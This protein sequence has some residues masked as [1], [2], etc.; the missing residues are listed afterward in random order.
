MD[1][2]DSLS[3]DE[4][5]Q[6]SHVAND[7]CVRLRALDVLPLCVGIVVTVEEDRSLNAA[8]IRSR[9]PEGWDGG[10]VVAR[11]RAVGIEVLDTLSMT[12]L[13]SLDPRQH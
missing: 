5:P 8:G 6:T 3:Q 7:A 1:G 10:D 9:M 12:A 13:A 2:R 4:L 11:Y